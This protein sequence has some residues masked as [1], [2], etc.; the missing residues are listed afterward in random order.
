MLSIGGRFGGLMK[1]SHQ[2]R[3]C[4]EAIY[5]IPPKV[6]ARRQRDKPRGKASRKKAATIAGRRRSTAAVKSQSKM[7]D[8]GGGIQRNTASAVKS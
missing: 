1:L 3:A 5:Y 8:P 6:I 7:F 4:D 2:V